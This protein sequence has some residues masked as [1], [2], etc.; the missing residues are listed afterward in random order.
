MREMLFGSRL[1]VLHKQ[2]REVRPIAVGYILRCLAA[3]CANSHVIEKRSEEPQPIQVGTGVSGGAEAAVHAVRRLVIHMPDDHVFVKLNFTDPF[4]TVRRDLILASTEY[5]TP[6]LYHSVHASL[7][8]SPML[9]YGNNF[10]RWLTTGR[11][12]Q[13]SRIL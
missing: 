9:K 8:C 7:A 4:N 2:D 5:K 1:I 13:Q 6:K 10:R 12:A 3:K 11:S